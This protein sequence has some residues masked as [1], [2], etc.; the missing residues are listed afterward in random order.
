MYECVTI[1][2]C[3][4]NQ[5]VYYVNVTICVFLCSSFCDTH[6]YIIAC[7]YNT[8]YVCVLSVRIP[9]LLCDMP[10]MS[11]CIRHYTCVDS[12]YVWGPC[13][14]MHAGC[15]LC[16]LVSDALCVCQCVSAQFLHCPGR[17]DVLRLELE[18]SSLPCG[19]MESKWRAEQG[20]S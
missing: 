15:V 2:V 10:V 18:V 14:E 12:I 13:V 4:W 16:I 11:M 6:V 8:E 20:Q 7:A 17:L 9:M 1:Y 3:V 5:C 19:S